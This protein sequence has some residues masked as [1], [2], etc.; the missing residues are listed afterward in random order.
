MEFALISALGVLSSL[1][2]VSWIFFFVMPV[3]V[4]IFGLIMVMAMH[5]GIHS[6]PSMLLQG[7]R[8]KPSVAVRVLPASSSAKDWRREIVEI[9]N[10]R[11]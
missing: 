5:G 10:F 11:K 9:E 4:P 7:R 1:L 3:F 8:F 2:L 6:R